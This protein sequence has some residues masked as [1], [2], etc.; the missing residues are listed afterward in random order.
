LKNSNNG[1]KKEESFWEKSR[2]S[3]R[4]FNGTEGNKRAQ[5]DAF[6]ML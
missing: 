6:T 2:L 3:P 5:F 4:A 1:K